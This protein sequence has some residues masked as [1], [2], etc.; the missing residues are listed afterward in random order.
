[1]R[2]AKRHDL[3]LAILSLIACEGA[4]EP[5]VAVVGDSLWTSKVR[6]QPLTLSRRI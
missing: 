4:N 6:G 5:G 1:M 3:G 2:S